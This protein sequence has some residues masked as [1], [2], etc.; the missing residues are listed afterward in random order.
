MILRDVRDVFGVR[1]NVL[2]VVSVGVEGAD[3]G[4]GV[5]AP[6]AGFEV[7]TGGDDGSCEED[8][9]V[10]N[11]CAFADDTAFA[12]LALVADSAGGK[13]G[14]GADGGPVAD[15]D[16]GGEAGIKGA[17]GVHNSTVLDVGEGAEGDFVVVAADLK[18]REGVRRRVGWGVSG[19]VPCYVLTTALYQTLALSNNVTSPITLALGATNAS[20]AMVGDVPRRDITGRRTENT[21][22]PDS[23]LSAM[24]VSL[25]PL[26]TIWEVERTCQGA[27]GSGEAP[28]Q[29]TVRETTGL[30]REMTRAN[31]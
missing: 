11:Y 23:S 24:P 12:D 14:S 22:S 21:V 10:G 5:A 31:I 3:F 7:A 16:N 6:P 20:L 2:G 13:N 26:D 28:K 15:V 19:C 30:A 1:D 4:G 9:L 8:A 29:R 18:E 27:E 25:R 17:D